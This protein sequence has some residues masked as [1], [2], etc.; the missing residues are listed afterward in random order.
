MNEP[1][2]LMR[3]LAAAFHEIA[4]EAVIIPEADFAAWDRVAKAA[5]LHF[6]NFKRRNQKLRTKWKDLDQ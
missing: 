4:P 2:L 1:T 5:T 3:R 6:M